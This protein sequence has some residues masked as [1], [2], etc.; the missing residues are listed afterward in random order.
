[1]RLTVLFL[2]VAWAVSSVGAQEP[3]PQRNRFKQD[4]AA[5]EEVEA[6]IRSFEGKGAIGTIQRPRPPTKRSG[7][8]SWPTGCRSTSS[9]PNRR[10]PNRCT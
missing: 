7:N 2:G 6:F 1:M 5:S 3:S 9:P 8:F 10:S 4:L